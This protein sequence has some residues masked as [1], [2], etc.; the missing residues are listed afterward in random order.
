M[1]RIATVEYSSKATLF[2]C[3]NI[4]FAELIT[5]RILDSTNCFN[6]KDTWEFDI[7]GMAL[8]SEHLGAIESE[9]LDPNQDLSILRRG[10]WSLFE[11]ENLIP[12]RFVDHYRLHRGH[13]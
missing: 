9:S 1:L 5:W 13:D 10:K 3:D 7:G 12:A 2:G 8:P 6:A 11:L 4:A